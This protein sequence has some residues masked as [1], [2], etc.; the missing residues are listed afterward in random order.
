MPQRQI[1]RLSMR[2]LLM[3]GAPIVLADAPTG[4][5]EITADVVLL[6]CNIKDDSRDF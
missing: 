6:F 4:E 5:G 2:A 1:S 3:G